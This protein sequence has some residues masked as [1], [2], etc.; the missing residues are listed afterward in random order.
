VSGKRDFEGKIRFDAYKRG[1]Y[2]FSVSEPYFPPKSLPPHLKGKKIEWVKKEVDDPNSFDA[3]QSASFGILSR[4]K[5]FV[6][7]PG[8][9][10]FFHPNS[11]MK[12][13]HPNN[14]ILSC[15][16]ESRN[17]TLMEYL[18]QQVLL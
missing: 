4:V 14:S 16:A 13:F 12:G 10:G 5:Y 17:V 1:I 8:A 11:A 18:L 3:W 2:Q 15:A 9:H 6:E 7:M